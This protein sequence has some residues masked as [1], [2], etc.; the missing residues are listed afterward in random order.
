[1]ISG[2]IRFSRIAGPGTYP[3]VRASLVAAVAA[4]ALVTLVSACGGGEGEDGTGEREARLEEI[5]QQKEALDAER[6]ELAAMEERLAQAESGEL[7]EG[8][9]VDPEQLRADIEQLDAQITEDA[10]T[11]NAAIAEF[12]N[13]AQLVE[14][15]PIPAPTQAALAL[16]ADEDLILA[17]EYIT[18]GGDYARAIRIYEDILSYAPDN[19]EVQAALERAQ[20]LRYMDEERF[21]Q[22]ENGMTK[23]EVRDVLGTVN[24]RNVR[25]YDDRDLEAWFYPK[26]Q[27]AGAAGVYFRKRGDRWEVYRADFEA[28]SAEGEEQEAG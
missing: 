16:K 15:E 11:L 18:E 21:A 17:R 9:E 14:G 12:I 7:P 8:E 19:P 5:R 23:P 3:A 13:A 4:L 25:T 24:P 20:E 6:D 26:G 22:V 10:E 2:F 27:N 28:V 1:M